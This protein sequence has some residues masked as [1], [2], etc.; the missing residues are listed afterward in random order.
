[1]TCTL[2]PPLLIIRISLANSQIQQQWSTWPVRNS[3]TLRDLLLSTG[4]GLSQLPLRSSNSFS[5]FRSQFRSFFP[6]ERL[7]WLSELNVWCVN[8]YF[9][10]NCVLTKSHFTWLCLLK[11]Y[12][13]MKKIHISQKTKVV[14]VNKIFSRGSTVPSIVYSLGLLNN[15]REREEQIRKVSLSHTHTLTDRQKRK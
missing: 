5:S 8:F 14:Y 7:S 10:I 11:T 1:M 13:H 15:E 2:L 3:L 9:G 4:D 6:L 12:F